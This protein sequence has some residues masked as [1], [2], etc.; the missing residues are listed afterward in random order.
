MRAARPEAPAAAFGARAC[1][2]SYTLAIGAAPWRSA[3]PAAAAPQQRRQSH[4]AAAAAAAG[5]RRRG[6]GARARSVASGWGGAA[7]ADGG[8]GGAGAARGAAGDALASAAS[9]LDI[10]YRFSRPHTM[11][12]TTLSVL[13][14]SALA[15][16]GGA[17]GG[18]GAAGGLSL[19]AAGGPPAAALGV[20]LASALLMNVAIVGLNQLFDVDIDRVNKPYLPLAS[21]ELSLGQGAAL[22]ASTAAASLALGAAAGSPPLMATLAGSGLLGVLYSVELP[23]MRWKRSPLLAAAC[24]LAVRA[25]LV[26]L[27][28][29][30]HMRAALAGGGGAAAAAAGLGAA[31]A[32][33]ALAAAPGLAFTVAFM[34]AFS[35]VI[36]LFKD[37]PDVKGDES[38]GVR[39]LSVRIG[40][41]AVFRVC[42]A[43]LGAAYAAGVAY[44]L[45]ACTG[46]LSRGVTTLGHAALGALLLRRS[47]AV[48]VRR[49]AELTGHYMFI[50]KLFYA[51]YALIPFLT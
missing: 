42:I 5:P 50:W 17:G 22:V 24:I 29:F 35:I 30:L 49:G 8:R 13:S 47:A 16:Q 1:S 11:L 46:P 45:L 33:G 6:D 2:T 12:G 27:G 31:G 28:F 38:A 19:L 9:A 39:T 3:A 37:I 41:E 25:L 48:D 32:A 26:Q 51:E 15:L 4:A 7:D 34:L 21:G 43:L 36:A 23:F 14:V 20:A 44:G 10:L 18:G 40:P